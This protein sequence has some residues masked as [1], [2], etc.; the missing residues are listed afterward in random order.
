MSTGQLMFLLLVTGFS[1]VIVG[2][3]AMGVQLVVLHLFGG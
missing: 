3:A 2:A 1:L